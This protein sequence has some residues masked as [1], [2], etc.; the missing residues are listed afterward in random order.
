M[1]SLGLFACCGAHRVQASREI[2][3]ETGDKKW[4]LWDAVKVIAPPEGDEWVDRVQILGYY[5]NIP[6]G[7]R[8]SFKDQMC[9]V[10]R[11]LEDTWM[12][13]EGDGLKEPQQSTKQE[14]RTY[15][16]S[17]FG[18]SDGVVQAVQGLLLRPASVWNL[19]VCLMKGD[20]KEAP[21]HK[22]F[23]PL[24]SAHSLHSFSGLPHDMAE[25]LLI[26]IINRE[27]TL[28]QACQLG[29][30]LRTEA[31]GRLYMIRKLREYYPTKTKNLK[32]WVQFTALWPPIDS[33]LQK[34]LGFFGGRQE[35]K[36]LDVPSVN[37]QLRTT[38]DWFEQ[39]EKAIHVALTDFPF[40]KNIY[41]PRIK[42][43]TYQD[44]VFVLLN[45]KTESASELLSPRD[46]G[47]FSLFSLWFGR[48]VLC[49]EVALV[50]PDY[51]LVQDPKL[52]TEDC[53]S[54]LLVLVGLITEP[55][56]CCLCCL[57]LMFC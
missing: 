26:K 43:S 34:S 55:C 40:V 45:C 53:F 10:R 36:N 54:C 38:C 15:I 30:E 33:L 8:L 44:Q 19:V 56:S 35:V 27:L 29:V 41:D 16:K 23:H 50:L 4:L 3:E 2:A 9:F 6:F 51:F 32:D 31:R 37:K 57:T 39:P 1:M 42:I 47:T 21:D 24:T 11:K 20:V 46:Y 7:Q 22:E 14:F 48:T 5:D 52:I 12:N 28:K 13:A 25:E 18:G 17:I 49:Y